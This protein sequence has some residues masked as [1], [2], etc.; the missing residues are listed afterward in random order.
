MTPMARNICTLLPP[1]LL[2]LAFKPFLVHTIFTE[3]H[4]ILCSMNLKKVEL[5]CLKLSGVAND[6]S[7]VTHM[8]ARIVLTPCLY[9]A[10]SVCFSSF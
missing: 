1:L 7:K 10:C 6:M 5:G 8:L 9:F 4:Y 2:I 3:G